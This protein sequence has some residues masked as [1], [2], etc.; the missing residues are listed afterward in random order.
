MSDVIET[1]N[2]NEMEIGK[3]RQYASH[4]RVPLPKTATKADIIKA[5]E[6]KLNGKVIPELAG[7]GSQVRPGYAKIR[8]L[9]DSTPGASNIPVYINANGYEATLPRGVDII[10]PMRVVRLLNDA[11][12]KRRKQTLTPDASGRE[13]FKESTVLAPSYPFQVLEMVPG[14]EVMTA[15]EQQKA[16]MVKPRKAYR[17]LFGR[18]PQNSAQLHK[19]IEQGL[20]KLGEDD[21]VPVKPEAI[22]ED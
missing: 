9:E 13:I 2:F 4:V 22:V 19:A 14:P 16:R 5:I 7:S 1:P 10:V 20:I 18:W 8:L 21:E 15:L 12:V 11:V 3:L 6:A 17:K